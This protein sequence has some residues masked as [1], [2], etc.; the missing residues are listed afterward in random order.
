MTALKPGDRTVFNDWLVE[1][2]DECTCDTPDQRMY[3][4]RDGCGF[5]PLVNLTDMTRS[6][7]VAVVLDMTAAIGTPEVVYRR[8]HGESMKDAAERLKDEVMQTAH[9]VLR[10]IDHKPRETP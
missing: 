10:V 7:R 4:H 1:Y 2:V 6:E 9:D 5:E 3:G 8:N